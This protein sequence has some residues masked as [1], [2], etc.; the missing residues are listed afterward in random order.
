MS[1]LQISE[2]MILVL[3]V[4][5]NLHEIFRNNWPRLNQLQPAYEYSW[6]TRKNRKTI[7]DMVSIWLYLEFVQ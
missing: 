1:S 2:K 7:I 5:R 3:N 6:N 4:F